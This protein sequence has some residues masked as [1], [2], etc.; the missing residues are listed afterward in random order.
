MT[1]RGSEFIA[2]LTII[3]KSTR[4]MPM[5]PYRIYRRFH[6]L[7]LYGGTHCVFT[8]Y[9]LNYAKRGQVALVM[10]IKRIELE[11]HLDKLKL[12]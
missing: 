7:V 5:N 11:C 6:S 9:L 1:I 8:D 2:I 12:V 3:Y 4:K 10:F